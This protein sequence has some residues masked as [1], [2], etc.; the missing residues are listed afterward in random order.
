MKEALGKN[1]K[2][3]LRGNYDGN[4]WMAHNIDLERQPGRL[5]L[6]DKF[7]RFSS[8]LGTVTKFI[9]T[10][11]DTTDQWWGLTVSDIVKNGS[12][13]STAGT[14]ATDALSNSPNDPLDA[15]IHELANGEQRLIVTRPTEIAILNSTA[16]ANAW[17]ADWGSTVPLTP[18]PTV[19]PSLT[20][21]PIARLQRLV[22]VANKVNGIPKIDTIDKDDVV[23]LGRL[24]F[25]PIYTV[26]TIYT[27]SNRFWIGLQNDV[28]GKAKVIEWD[29]FSDTYNNEYELEAGGIPMSGFIAQ[30]IPYFI[31]ELGEILKYTGGGFEPFADFCNREERQNFAGTTT[32][33]DSHVPAYGCHVEG[34]LVYI[35]VN[36]PII[37]SGGQGG[38]ATAMS[39]PTRRLRSGT[40]VLNLRNRNLYHNMG[41][42]EHATPGTDINYGSSPLQSIGAIMKPSGERYLVGSAAP[43]VGG[44]TW[45]AA[46]TSGIY[47][48]TPNNTQTSNGG[49]NRGYFVTPYLP[50]GDVEAMWSNLWVKFKKFVNSNNRIVVKWRVAEP[51]YN[52]TMVDQGGN[53][54][55]IPTAP[56]TWVNATSFT[57]KVPIG[58]AVGDEV[59]ILVGDNAGCLFNIATLS[60]TP[61][62]ST[63]I[64][65]TLSETAPTTGTDTGLA[66]FDNFKTETAISET[67]IGSKNCPFS[68]KGHGEF[69]QLKIYLIGFDVEIDEL[70]PTWTVKTQAK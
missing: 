69:I 45:Q 67:T 22:A 41:F 29:G 36:A 50:I 33:G 51:L 62:G 65:V 11:A 34:K 35:N 2:G 12:P 57:C 60:A 26:R 20:Y 55:E 48:Q 53:T 56:I 5:T 58:V 59:E 15:V 7:Q 28:G 46:A 16:S 1:W 64:T 24:T 25:D 32:A 70:L 68:S 13:I 54:M 6:A 63:S 3:M 31:T 17:D 52:G 40:W 8:G 61:D 4:L 23:S 19:S 37:L 14:W 39:N 30:D 27:S 44:A 18:I 43:F 47:V 42:G 49:R 10:N 21:R 9:R 66:R 38:S